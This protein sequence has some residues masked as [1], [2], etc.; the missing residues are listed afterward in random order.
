M[1]NEGNKVCSFTAPSYTALNDLLLAS[2]TFL[3]EKK[4]PAVHQTSD[5]SGYHSYIP[6]DW[7]R[8]ACIS[9]QSRIP[10]IH[11]ASID[12]IDRA[13]SS[14]SLKF[15]VWILNAMAFIFKV[16]RHKYHNTAKI[17]VVFFTDN[18]NAL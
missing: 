4:S 2:G 14:V 16:T 5:W 18:D 9:S 17:L 8:Q 3:P 6:E 10:A 12:H 1:G 7:N 15:S 13:V 11:S